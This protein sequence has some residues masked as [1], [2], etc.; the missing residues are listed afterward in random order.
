MRRAAFAV[1]LVLLAVVPT[2]LGAPPPG[3]RY[4]EQ[5]RLVKTPFTPAAPKSTLTEAQAILALLQAPKVEHW[6]ARYPKASLVKQATYDSTYRDW[7]VKVWSGAAGEI[8]TGRVDDFSGIVTEAWTGPQVAWK[9]ARGGGAAF[10]G[11]KINSLPVW[12]AFCAAF[13]LGLADLRRPF[14]VRNLDLLALLS[15][16]VSLW[17]FNHGHIFASASLVYP[18]FG[19]LLAR[20]IW[21]GV[22]DRPPPTGRP[23]WPIWLLAA[24]TV[25]LG[26]FKVGLNIRESNVIDVGFA[27][28]IGAER[29]SHGQSPYGNF[30]VEDAR[31]PCGPA[32][33]D[34]EIRERI[35]A[36][37]RCEAANPNGD[38]YGPMSYIA[39]LPG[40]AFF[41][42]NGKWDSLPAA[43]FTSIAFDL[44]CLIG[45]GLVGRRFGGNR[46]GVTLAFAWAAYP[47]TQYVSNS[48]T[49]DAIMPA[50]LIWGFW[51]ATSHWAR[52]LF[53]GLA[54]WTKFAALIVVPMWAT[55][56]EFRRS[57]RTALLFAAGF[58]GATAASFWILFLE[59]N[60]LH[61][62]RLFWDRTIPTQIDRH[63][64]FS[65]WDWG[66]YHAGLP[67]LA[68]LQKVLEVALVAG[69]AVLAFLPRRKTPLQ[70]AALTGALLIGFE[71]VLTHWFYLY[72]PWFFGFVAYAV[73]AAEPKTAEA[74]V[75]SPDEHPTRELVATG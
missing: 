48:N 58:A 2:A 19:Y 61:A 71:A 62:A 45:L 27:G 53:A 66:Q 7:N 69:A 11:K 9:M 39:Y 16:S 14:S 38:T 6:V 55:Y 59:P 36:N 50:F 41:G 3:P 42:W 32:D 5:G 73:L 1:A 68:W 72:L 10:G 60:P 22:R 51:L 15:F 18:G 40:Y 70:L 63:S 33:R 57:R 49:N 34:G 65:V 28:P 29:I 35:Q 17:Y 54:G 8:A 67:D 52:G 75:T 26:G 20:T 74:S 4:D 44:L 30:P 21:I 24:A 43:H 64:P 37:G 31:K 47:F 23:V 25:F 12:L 13:L 46:L 56:P